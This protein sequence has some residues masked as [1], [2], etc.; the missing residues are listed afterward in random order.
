MRP[1]PTPAADFNGPL[2]GSG[3][4][5]EA[6]TLSA[7]DHLEQVLRLQ[8]VGTDRFRADS[9]PGRFGR[10]FG[11]QLVAQALTAAAATVTELAPHAIHAMFLRP[12]DSTAPL[13]IAVERSRDG[14]T[15]SARQV[16]ISQAGRAL[17][18]ALVSF[19]TNPESSE[20]VTVE[21]SVTASE[22]HPLLQHWVHRAPPALAGSAR[23]WVDTPPP[24][25]MRIADAPVFLGGTP[26]GGPRSF[27]MRLP[28]AIDGGPVAHTTMLAYASDYLL[29]DTAFRAHPQPVGYTTHHGLTL[30]HT[31][32]LH[33]PVR[34][35]QWHHYTQQIVAAAGHRAV[36]KGTIVDAAGRHVAS[37]AQEVLV[38]PIT[39]PSRSDPGDTG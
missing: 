12:G 22:A 14:R 35:D 27:W 17:M 3:G 2:L 33:R 21:G 19:D 8:P 9:E 38:R 36:V 10:I 39:E 4:P 5:L 18:T 25:E 23:T 37:T 24:L 13:D 16:V 1:T 20:A 6:A 30:D 15:M 29:V 34:F 31:I 26:A 11:G 7:L 32:W 28:R